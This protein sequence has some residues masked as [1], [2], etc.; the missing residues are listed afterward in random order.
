[1]GDRVF[2]WNTSWEIFKD[3]PIIG[4]GLNTFFQNFKERRND[5]WKNKKGSYAHNCYLQMAC[6]TGVVGLGAFLWLVAAYFHSVVRSLKK[7]SEAFYG[8][9]L[10]GIS[11]GVF[12]FLIHSFTD[13][14]LYS[15]NL[16]TL[17]WSAIGI[18]QAMVKT[19]E[20]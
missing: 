10:L 20:A 17:F 5:E 13:T 6:D 9:I 12:A 11:T 18:S 16:A 8:S 3:H 4:S 14:N 7:I 1:V 19:L 2:M 15:L